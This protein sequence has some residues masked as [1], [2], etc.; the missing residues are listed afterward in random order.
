VRLNTCGRTAVNRKSHASDE[1]RIV[2]QEEGSRCRDLFRLAFA[3]NGVRSANPLHV[4]GI[5]EQG[6]CHR[7][8]DHPRHNGI[9]ADAERSEF[10]RHRLGEPHHSVLRRRIGEAVGYSSDPGRRAQVCDRCLCLYVLYGAITD[11]LALAKVSALARPIPLPAP[12]TNATLPSKTV[13]ISV[14]WI[15]PLI[16]SLPAI[17]QPTAP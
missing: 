8:P 3:T 6:R 9:D 17:R 7:R 5:L 10:Q 14:S 16:I 12:V 2:G 1:A 4:F 15:M 11:A 13:V